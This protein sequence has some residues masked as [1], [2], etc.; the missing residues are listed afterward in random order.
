[1]S[2]GIK[3]ALMYT[4]SILVFFIQACVKHIEFKLL[5]HCIARPCEYYEVTFQTAQ[6]V[7]LGSIL[8]IIPLLVLG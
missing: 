3:S 7:K 6:S 2:I 5:R 8:L 4:E 1:M